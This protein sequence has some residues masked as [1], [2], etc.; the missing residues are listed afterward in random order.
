M[1]GKGKFENF[2][3]DSLFDYRYRVFTDCNRSKLVVV[4]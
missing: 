4:E 1:E 2:R 3:T